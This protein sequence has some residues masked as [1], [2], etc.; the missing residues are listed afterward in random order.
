MLTKNSSPHLLNT[1]SVFLSLILALLIADRGAT[2][3]TNNYWR[4]YLNIDNYN[5]MNPLIFYKQTGVEIA[6]GWYSHLMTLLS[7]GKLFFFF[8]YS[9]LI[10]FFIFQSAKKIRIPYLPVLV[11][12]LSSSFF[13][14][15]QF[16]QMRQGLAIAIAM[17]SLIA[18][19]NTNKK[20]V[21][22]YILLLI[23]IFVHQTAIILI[24]IFITFKAYGKFISKIKHKQIINLL[25]ITL[26]ILSLKYLVMPSLIMMSSR[27]AAYAA[28]DNFAATRSLVA[29]PNIRTFLVLVITSILSNS[30]VR[31][32]ENYKFL[33]FCLGHVLI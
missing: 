28:T 10:F 27:V 16:M 32:N 11:Y 22:L 2:P 23:S 18:I 12:Y 9:Y 14:T 6:F 20:K 3:D 19:L 21:F 24:G 25:L 1:F 17:F 15:Q 29:L 4:I 31:K 5:I 33:F 8:V 7:S 26:A 13:Y 30:T